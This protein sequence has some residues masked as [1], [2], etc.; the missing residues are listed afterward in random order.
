MGGDKAVEDVGTL[1]AQSNGP[2]NTGTEPVS[3][4]PVH[5]AH[6]F[7]GLIPEPG[8]TAQGPRNVWTAS[9]SPHFRGYPVFP[10]MWALVVLPGSHHLQNSKERMQP[11]R[12]GG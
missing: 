1:G 10:G 5:S 7:L 12:G 11:W 3:S 9:T 2:L 4:C 6:L 8:L